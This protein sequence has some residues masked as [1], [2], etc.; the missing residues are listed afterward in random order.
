MHRAKQ[1]ACALLAASAG[2]TTFIGCAHEEPPAA[3]EASLRQ[4]DMASRTVAGV[5]VVARLGN[6]AGD[7]NISSEVTPVRVTINNDSGSDIAIHYRNLQLLDGNGNSYRALPLQDV[8]GLVEVERG[9]KSQLELDARRSYAF[10]FAPYY[11]KT[12]PD[13][14]TYGGDFMQDK[15]YL[16]TFGPQIEV[17]SLPTKMM[18]Q[19]ALPEGVLKNGGYLDGYLYFQ[20]VPD[21]VETVSFSATFARAESAGPTVAVMTLPVH[22]RRGG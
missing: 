17:K 6:W 15:D 16:S 8:G 21:D 13:L 4:T 1:L 9:A 2:L 20:H 22:L 3:S 7:A 14:D 10:K 19:A 18:W 11:A 12:N 5:R